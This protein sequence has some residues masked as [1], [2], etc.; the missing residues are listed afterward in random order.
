MAARQA[1]ELAEDRLRSGREDVI[2]EDAGRVLGAVTVPAGD[3]PGGATTHRF[4]V[5][6]KLGV[7]PAVD[8]EGVAGGGVVEGDRQVGL[9]ALILV[10]VI[11]VD[12]DVLIALVHG[13]VAAAEAE[14][15]LSGLADEPVARMPDARARALATVPLDRVV[16]GWVVL[17]QDLDPTAPIPFLDRHPPATRLDEHF[18]LRS[19]NHVLARVGRIESEPGYPVGERNGGGIRSSL[20]ADRVEVGE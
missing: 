13:V 5:E 10:L 8:K 9:T 1:R 20:D 6:A 7:I 12:V 14:V 16:S 4:R 17:L 19:R 18:Y 15:I 3:V 11:G 2:V